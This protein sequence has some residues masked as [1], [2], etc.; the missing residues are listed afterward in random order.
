MQCNF[1][2]ENHQWRYQCS[3]TVTPASITCVFD[4]DNAKSV[5]NGQ[6]VM[7][8]HVTTLLQD[9]LITVLDA[10]IKAVVQSH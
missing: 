7:S 6:H 10:D 1:D 2:I 9:Q 4:R 5:W 8:K 3:M